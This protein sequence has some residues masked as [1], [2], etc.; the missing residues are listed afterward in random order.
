MSGLNN[1]KYLDGDGLIKF[2]DICCANFP[3]RDGRGAT[4]NW[5]INIT[6]NAKTA[7]F[8]ITA[9]KLDTNAGS[10]TK[11]VYFGD[12]IPKQCN[13]KLT[14]DISGNAG[15]ADKWKT[16]RKITLAGDVT[17]NVSIDGSKDVT[18]TTEVDADKHEHLQY[19]DITTEQSPNTVYAGP[20]SGTSKAA[21]SFRKLDANDL[22]DLSGIYLPKTGG[23]ISGQLGFTG[24]KYPHIYGNGTNL[25]FG[26]SKDEYSK[27]VIDDK[28]IR[29]GTTSTQLGRSTYPWPVAYITKVVGDLEGTADE[30]SIAHQTEYELTLKTPNGY[31]VVFNGSAN[32][33]F[34]VTLADLGLTKAV[35]YIGKTTTSIS[36]GSTTSTI[37][38]GGV[39]TKV[40]N[41]DIVIDASDSHEYIWNGSAWE[42]FGEDATSG[43][44]KPKQTAVSSP[45]ASGND[46]SFIDTI[47]QD[48]NGKI[49]ATKK[50]VNFSG[51]KPKQTA[52]SSPTASGNDISFIDTISQDE[53]GKITATRKNVRSA[54]SSQSGVVTTGAQTFAGVKTFKD[55]LVAGS[56]SSSSEENLISIH[57][58][59]TD[60]FIMWDYDG[61]LN[62]GA[63]WRIGALGSGVGNTNYFTIQSGT[64]TPDNNTWSTVLNIGQTDFTVYFDKTPKVGST[65][66]SLEGH[67]HSQYSTTDTKNTA[68]ST[69]TSSK[70]FLIGATTQA[71][72][73]QTYS[74][75]TAYVGTDGCM[76]ST[77]FITVSDRRMKDNINN[78][79]DASKS[80]ELGFYEF[81]Y[82]TG[83]HSAGH[84]AQEVIE[85]YPKFVH[86]KETETE[87][88]SIDY[89]GLHS[90]QIKALKDKVDT[91]KTENKELRE[92]LEKLEKLIEKFI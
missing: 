1:K 68:G 50:N 89:T 48:E 2:W 41:G 10:A 46:I 5:D 76:Y 61:D 31:D 59:D 32:K 49:T 38:I 40:T 85:V 37:T 3:A 83:G 6:G 79:D 66:V 26:T 91:L 63:S 11:P 64:S 13:D 19:Y 69:D 44:Y 16:A 7:T 25:H 92:R 80:L 70:I 74:H 84:I 56:G 24:T 23:T 82:K 88:L 57:Y 21:A 39:S 73:P 72:N 52:V 78:I 30:A 90:V 14:V 28:S 58:K 9:G 17:G 12:G 4:G 27:V 15:S 33:T 35:K 67:T 77:N 34:N 8:A 75:D 87:H 45:T 18:L 65:S 60:K 86:G 81:D 53:N 22:P 29:T 54:S 20:S 47:S 43:N 55:G 71:A 42:K 36:D 51:Y 62:A